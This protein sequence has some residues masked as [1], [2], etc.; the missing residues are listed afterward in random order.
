MIDWITG[1]F[2]FYYNDLLCD[3]EVL[4]VSPTGEVERRTLKRKVVTGS[5]ESNITIR[6]RNVD[7]LG[8][9]CEVELSGNPVKFLQGH[10]LFGTLD[11][12]NLVYSALERVSHL[13][14]VEQPLQFYDAWRLGLGTISRVDIN[15]MYSLGSRSNVLQWLHSA[16]NSSRTRSQSAVTKGSTVYWNKDSRRWSVKAYSKGQEVELPRNNKPGMVDFNRYIKEW[17]DDK[18]RIELTLKSNEL[19]RLSLHTLAEFAKIEP[20]DL[21]EEYREKLVMADQLELD[22]NAMSLMSTREK[23]VYGLWLSGVDV[24]NELSKSAFYRHRRALLAYGIDI[25]ISKPKSNVVPL[26]RTIV[27]EP[28][29]VPD[30][31]HGTELYYEPKKLHHN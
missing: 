27:L 26:V 19:R 17:S 20:Y 16:S 29:S 18:L 28:A 14:E 6:T 21:F 11:T 4:V 1:V 23:S 10:N 5:Y 9:T 31:A 25:S 15:R 2:P 22:F 30:W 24:R 3:G 8:H 7:E 13:L 12:V